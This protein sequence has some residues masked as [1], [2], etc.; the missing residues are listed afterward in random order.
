MFR[1]LLA[2]YVITYLCAEDIS[3]QTE[4]NINVI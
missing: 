2:Y 4:F 3:L 1:S